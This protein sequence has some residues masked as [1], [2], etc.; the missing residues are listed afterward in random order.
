MT[1]SIR[2]D[3]TERCAHYGS[4]SACGGRERLIWENTVESDPAEWMLIF[5]R[6]VRKT[7]P[8]LHL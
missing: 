2:F 8:L 4:Y 6:G 3:I 7:H 5:D 1:R